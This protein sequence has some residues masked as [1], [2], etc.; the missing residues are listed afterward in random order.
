MLT[1]MNDWDRLNESAVHTHPHASRVIVVSTSNV[2]PNKGK[3]QI[4]CQIKQKLRSS[5]LPSCTRRAQDRKAHPIR[6]GD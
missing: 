1:S 6:V 3:R 2:I 5:L 4:Y